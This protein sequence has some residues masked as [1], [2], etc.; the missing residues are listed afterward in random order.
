M[1]RDAYVYWFTMVYDNTYVRL[2][3]CVCVLGVF[4]PF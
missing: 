1:W 3:V 4:F 2:Y